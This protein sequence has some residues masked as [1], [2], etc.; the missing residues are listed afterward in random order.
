MVEIA[1]NTVE[2][3]MGDLR[4]T[5]ESIIH[6]NKVMKSALEYLLDRYFHALVLQSQKALN[7]CLSYQATTPSSTP[8]PDILA[9]LTDRNKVIA[10]VA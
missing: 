9:V 1:L 4:N 5:L 7:I 3:Y 6:H 2:D 8:A 10:K